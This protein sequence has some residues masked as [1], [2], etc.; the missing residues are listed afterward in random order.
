M[1]YL[2]SGTVLRCHIM[3]QSVDMSVG[4]AEVGPMG[5]IDVI[6]K[7]VKGDN[8]RCVSTCKQSR[9]IVCG[10]DETGERA[11]SHAHSMQV[12]FSI[13]L[14]SF[15]FSSLFHLSHPALSQLLLKLHLPFVS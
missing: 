1:S 4:S 7:C 14:L 12:F 8:M 3:F 15:Y 2:R 11:T 6:V 13:F 9:I 10:R 5:M